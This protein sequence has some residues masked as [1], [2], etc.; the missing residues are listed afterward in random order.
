MYR[1]LGIQHKII[2]LKSTGPRGV[3]V[4]SDVVA[5]FHTAAHFRNVKTW[6]MR[7][8]YASGVKNF[9]A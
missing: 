9:E 4:D 5:A 8:N 2:S 7:I 1:S 6:L 3:S